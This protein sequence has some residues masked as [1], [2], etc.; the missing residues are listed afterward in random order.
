MTWGAVLVRAELTLRGG[1]LPG[2]VQASARTEI[3][4]SG[5]DM[6]REPGD[7]PVESPVLGS[8]ATA[9][10]ISWMIAGSP[11]SVI[12]P[13]IVL[14]GA[15]RATSTMRAEHLVADLDGADATSL[16]IADII[17]VGAGAAS[18]PASTPQARFTRIFARYPGCAVAVAA[19]EDDRL[20]GLREGREIRFVRDQGV[21]TAFA[22]PETGDGRRKRGY[23]GTRTAVAC[24]SLVYL[25]VAGGRLV[26]DLDS[27]TAV[28]ASD[29]GLS[30]SWFTCRAERGL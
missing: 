18:P 1:A 12:R 23:T 4:R 9:S 13:F 2:V 27:M 5:C 21:G 17:I 25:W 11:A 29:G 22:R 16:E 30:R 6:D 24:A 3:H 10:V 20:V 19:A 7:S 8:S 28:A 15:C 14:D 26:D